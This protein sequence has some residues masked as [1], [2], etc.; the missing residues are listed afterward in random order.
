MSENR[1]GFAHILIPL[2]VVLIVVIAGLV[3]LTVNV[4]K[5]SKVAQEPSR[6]TPQD[7]AMMEDKKMVK[8]SSF[9][10]VS[11]P[12]LLFTGGYA[13]PTISKLE[14]GTLVMYL[15]NFSKQPSTYEAHTSKDGLTWTKVSANLPNASTGRA[16]K[17]GN[18]IRLYYPDQTPIRPTDPPAS[19]LSAVSNDGLSFTKESGTRIDP[20]DG[21]Y[22]EGP[23][24]FTLPDGSFKMYFSENQTASAEERISSIWGATSKDGLTW[25]RDSKVTI[26][27]ADAKP[28]PQALH[29]FVLTKVDGSFL[30]FY[31]VHSEVYAA[32]S[33]D[34]INWTKLGAIGVHGADVDGYYLP[35]GSIRLYYGDFSEKTSGVVYT[36]DIKEK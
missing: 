5:T 14:D 20:K 11:A 16:V 18:K 6:E 10:K 30:M 8:G 13:D 26:D 29:P 31:N 28:W 3:F 33:K 9:E 17:F 21:Y 32:E 24:V 12:K 22:L 15:N 35:D 25:V 27:P 19:I 36:I 2:V 23:T 34:G 7:N 1:K 4:Q